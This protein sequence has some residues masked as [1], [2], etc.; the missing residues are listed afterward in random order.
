MPEALDLML[1]SVFASVITCDR[2]VLTLPRPLTP[3][4]QLGARFSNVDSGA[5]KTPAADLVA[6]RV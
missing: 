3:G 5:P 6:A 2:V 1:E 4:S